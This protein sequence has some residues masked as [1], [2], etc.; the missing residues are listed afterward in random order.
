[1]PRR[2][3]IF[4]RWLLTSDSAARFGPVSRASST[5]LRCFHPPLSVLNVPHDPVAG[6]VVELPVPL[7]SQVALLIGYLIFDPVKVVF[8]GTL[9]GRTLLRVVVL[10]FGIG[11]EGLEVGDLCPRP[12]LLCVVGHGLNVSTRRTLAKRTA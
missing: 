12:A 9:L 10:S 5:P 8:G 6:V 4:R 1:M 7:E 3:L 11:Q 2:S